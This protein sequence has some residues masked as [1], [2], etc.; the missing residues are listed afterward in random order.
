MTRVVHFNPYYCLKYCQG[1]RW[2]HPTPYNESVNVMVVHSDRTRVFF[3]IKT[4]A[5]IIGNMV[6]CCSGTSQHCKDNL[7]TL[8]LMGV[9]KTGVGIAIHATI[10]YF[11][12]IHWQS[13]EMMWEI[14]HA[15][16][17]SFHVLQRVSPEPC[18]ATMTAVISRHAEFVGLSFQIFNQFLLPADTEVQVL[19]S[20]SRKRKIWFI[21]ILQP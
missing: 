16:H 15:F 5:H 12:F 8:I 7:Y 11:P 13:N 10:Y 4:E 9:K 3:Q 20:L 2:L 17:V 6:I 14:Y 18:H 21:R 19:E 1:Y